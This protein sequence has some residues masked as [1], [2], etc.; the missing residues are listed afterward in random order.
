MV[1]P[2]AGGG[3]ALSDL[4]SR[5]AVNVVIGPEG[6]W[7]PDELSMM[8]EAGVTRVSLGARTLRAETAPLVALAALFE[9]WRAW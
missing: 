7:T 2:S 6:G 3:S 4:A 1:E 8:A 5:D 9:A